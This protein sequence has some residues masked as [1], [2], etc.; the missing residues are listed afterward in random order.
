MASDF[1]SKMKRV[2]G[3]FADAVLV[4]TI[5]RIPNS[6]PMTDRDRG[7]RQFIGQWLEPLPVT[8]SQN[9][10]AHHGRITVRLARVP[11]TVYRGLMEAA[12]RIEHWGKLVVRVTG[13]LD[14]RGSGTGP[15][16]VLL[17]GFGAPG[18]DLVP[19]GSALALPATVRFVYPEAPL[20]LGFDSGYGDARAWWWLDPSEFERAIDTG[21]VAELINKVPEGL[22]QA[23]QAIRDLM[24]H[25]QKEL[26]VD[27]DQIVLGGFSQ[28]AV[29]A[30]DAALGM[31]TQIAGLVLLSGAIVSRQQWLARLAAHRKC[32]VFQSHGNDDPI[33]PFGL[34]EQL[35]QTLLDA[36]LTVQW[37]P[38]AGGHGIPVEVLQ[39]LRDFLLRVFAVQR[40]V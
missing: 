6:R 35:H 26:G 39:S 25:I 27:T 30:M 13:G 32:P 19:L 29:L 12:M 28:G 18:S 38:F 22:F 14:G 34:A 7:F 10:G 33:L 20:A 1:P 17:H 2:D 11:S 36:G 4:Q 5:Q 21:T 3:G 31:D 24:L 15:V 8:G 9:H 23:S 16:V 40:L 37:H